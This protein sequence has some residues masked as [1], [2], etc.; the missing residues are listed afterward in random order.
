[1]AF[2]LPQAEE[3]LIKVA[4]MT[5][6]KVDNKAKLDLIRLEE[7]AIR[8]EMKDAAEEQALEKA[9]VCRNHKWAVLYASHGCTCPVCKSDVP[10]SC[11]QLRW[12]YLSCV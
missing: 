8:K 5:G 4:E 11:V 9:Q 3:A 6:D 1:M 10:Q 2:V 7:A 12:V